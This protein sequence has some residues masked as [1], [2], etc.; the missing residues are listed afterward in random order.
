M[1]I[2]FKPRIWPVKWENVFHIY[3]KGRKLET[4]LSI[5]FKEVL[6]AAI[7][8]EENRENFWLIISLFDM[9][10][11]MLLLVINLSTCINGHMFEPQPS[12]MVW[13]LF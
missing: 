5:L 4:V 10:K 3:T 6:N 12:F 11:L 1:K 13:N 9:I 8:W 7:F 2:G